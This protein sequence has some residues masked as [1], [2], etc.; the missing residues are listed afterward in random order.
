M[1]CIAL[2][3]PGQQEMPTRRK[4]ELSAINVRRSRRPFARPTAS[5]PS[6]PVTAVQLRICTEHKIN[7]VVKALRLS[8]VR[9]TVR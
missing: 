5:L 8:I 7:V 6:A 3:L 2:K 9:K 1:T 4:D